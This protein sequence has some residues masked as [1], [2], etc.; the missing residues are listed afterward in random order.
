MK[1]RVRR[2]QRDYT[3]GFKLA[4]VEQIT[5]GEL[6]VWHAKE[7]YGIQG[8]STV[9][10]WLHKY[11]RGPAAKA[12]SWRSPP[13]A[14]MSD[15]SKLTPEQ[16]IRVLEA[17]LKEARQKAE[18]FEAVVAVLKKDHGVDVVKKPSGKSSRKRSSKG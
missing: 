7:R 13:K 14:S 6:S 1:T 5:R 17:Q 12:A 10:R 3:L 11:G 9:T 18:L 8:S 4:L 15:P 16:R 2:T